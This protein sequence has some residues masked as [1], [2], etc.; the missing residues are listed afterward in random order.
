MT[1][2][3]GGRAVIEASQ[4][5]QVRGAGPGKRGIPA[6]PPLIALT[7]TAVLLA[8]SGRYGYHRDELYFLRGGQ[9][10]A[11]GYLDQPPLTPLL[12]RAMSAVFDGSLVG[13][14]LP[15]ALMAGLVVLLTGWMTR[16]L[17]GGRGA[18]ALAA[19]CVAV[20]ALLLVVG[21]LL[22]TTTF[23]LLAWTALSWLLIR[24]LR[25]GGPI[26]LAAGLVAGV[27]LQNKTLMAFLLAGMG[28][29]LLLAGP[30]QVLRGRWPWL[31]TLLA[32][33]IWTPNL[34]WQAGH[35]WPLFELSATIASGGSGTSEPRWL[36]L[37]FQLVL[38][39]PLLVPVWVAGLYRF[40]RD[41][42]L[43]P[44]R[45]IAVAYPVLAAVFLVTGGKPYYLAGLYPV[46]LA[47]GAEPTLRWVRA[48]RSAVQA[49]LRVGLLAAAVALS[50]AVNAVLM[51]PLVPARQLAGTPIVAINYDAGETLGWPEFTRTLAGVAAALPG[52]ER[53]TAIVLAGNYGEA[54]AVDRFGAELAV[55]PA[56]S[57]YHGY[58]DWGPP[59]ESSGTTIAVGYPE[60]RL[61]EWFGSV[62]LA[63]RIDNGV[64]VPNDEQG[65]PVWLCRNRLAPWAA[66]WP[67]LL[68]RA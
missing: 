15:S 21:H 25:D 43:R 54:G 34:I 48:G 46:L 29:G 8:V 50:L 47:A 62:E 44:Y 30:R 28:I 41:P 2:A 67:T 37:P 16:E 33:L 9:E 35:G 13:L 40:A 65:R 45:A 59:P 14:R 49:R 58:G 60:E 31:G 22:S 51:L 61:R 11:F 63:A 26:W 52:A 20:S 27:G 19:G 57:G 39:S 18:Q 10:P 24:A 7:V 64:G 12:A 1:E 56:Y 3:R 6:L 5:S 32:V 38:I 66:I 42:A 17:G 23:D 36:L 55:P 68:R 53:A 4:A